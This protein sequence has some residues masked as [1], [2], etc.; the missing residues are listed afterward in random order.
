MGAGLSCINTVEGRLGNCDFGLSEKSKIQFNGAWLRKE[1]LSELTKHRA[2]D[3]VMNEVLIFMQTLKGCAAASENKL[4]LV[5]RSCSCLLLLTP[6][7]VQ[8]AVD[9]VLNDKNDLLI[10]FVFKAISFK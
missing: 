8:T 4:R 6:F 2:V 3:L 10:L 9:G 5:D 1:L 7:T